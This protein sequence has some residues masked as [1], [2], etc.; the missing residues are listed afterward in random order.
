[1]ISY[2][3]DTTAPKETLQSAS[4]IP[5]VHIFALVCQSGAAEAEPLDP[6][7]P[8]VAADYERAYKRP[9]PRVKGLR[10]QINSQHTGTIA[11]SYFGEV[12]FVS[13]PQVMI[14][15]TG[16]SGFIGS[17]LLE[18]LSALGMPARALVRRKTALASRRREPS[19][20]ISSPATASSAALEGVTTVIHLAGVTKALVPGRLLR[21][22]YARDRT[23][24]A[25]RHRPRPRFVHVSSLAAIGPSLDGVPVSEDAEPHPLTHYGKSKLEAERVRPQAPSRRRNRPPGGGLRPARHRRLSD[26]LKSISQ[27]LRARNRAAASDGSAAIY[28]ADLVDA[29]LAAARSPASRRP[30]L[31]RGTPQ[32]RPPGTISARPR[33]A[34][35][36]A[37]LACCVCRF[38]W[39]TRSAGCAE[40]WSQRHPQSGHRLARED[41]P[42]RAATTGSATPAAP[43]A[44]CGFD[45]ATPPRSR[46]RR[47]TLAWYKEAGWLNY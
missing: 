6:R 13:A 4:A 35:C 37:A 23:A 25:R 21:R 18:R 43:P 11:E 19:P 15:V 16:G 30:R 8:N 32:A 14:L 12:A 40:M 41:R 20:A 46:S 24:R 7:N 29:L 45:A 1:M 2:I 3:W 27:G 39:H 10:L 28:V 5:F 38:P 26:L 31:L 34:S 42:K 33:R 17:H 44:S 9:A 47:S 36:R 22:Q